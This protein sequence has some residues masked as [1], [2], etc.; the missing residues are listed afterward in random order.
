MRTDRLDGN[1][2]GID[3]P[4]LSAGLGEVHGLRDLS[5]SDYYPFLSL[6]GPVLRDK[7]WYYVAG[8]F[9]QVETPI[10]A[11]SQAFV[12][13]TRGFRNFGKATWQINQAHKLAFSLSVDRT[14][15]ENQGLDSLTAVEAGYLFERGGP[16]FTLKETGVFS[17]TY[18]LES[19]LSWFDNAFQRGPTLDPD[20][21]GNGV[22]WTDRNH[23]GFAE[24]TEYDSGEDYDGDGAFDVFEKPGDDRDHDNQRTTPGRA[25]STGRAVRTAS[26]PGCTLSYERDEH[27]SDYHRRRVLG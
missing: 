9:I 14:K 4:E 23:N 7:V 25:G 6:S 11:V 20:T 5:F 2:A 26:A 13:R 16:T 24:A 10:N 18:L 22:Q 21:N 1:G 8:E 17:P 12:T 27:G 19:S 3:P 15:D